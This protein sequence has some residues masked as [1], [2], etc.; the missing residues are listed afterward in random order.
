[1]LK[2]NDYSEEFNKLK[3]TGVKEHIINTNQLK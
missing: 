2:I 1:M 3:K